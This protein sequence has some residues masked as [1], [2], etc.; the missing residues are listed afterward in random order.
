MDREEHSMK[1]NNLKKPGL[2]AAGVLFGTAGIKILTSKDAKKLYT[3]C[4]AA[5]L[6]AKSCIMKT[7][8]TVQENCEDIYADAKQINE[9]RAEAKAAAEFAEEA[10]AE[11]E[12]EEETT[13]EVGAEAVEEAAE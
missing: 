6:R 2:F 9:E 13:E 1:I 8:T 12:T 10:E 5:V 3:N 7:A 4:T 11:E